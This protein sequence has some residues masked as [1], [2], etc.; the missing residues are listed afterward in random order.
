MTS[1]AEKSGVNENAPADPAGASAP[2]FEAAQSPTGQPAASQP[3]PEIVTAPAAYQPPAEQ[4]IMSEPVYA[5]PRKGPVRRFIRSLISHLVFAAIVTAAAFG[6][7]YHKEIFG[8]LGDELCTDDRLGGYMTKA[9][10]PVALEPVKAARQ[11]DGG[12]APAP[13]AAKQATSAPSTPV[14]LAPSIPAVPAAAPAPAEAQ[15]VAK[16]EPGTTS[17][18]KPESGPAKVITEPSAGAQPSAAAP[19]A[20]TP[21]VRETS[22]A[23]PV[24][25][26]DARSAQAHS[27]QVQASPSAAAANDA[28]RQ[29][30]LSPAPDTAAATTSATA[31]TT[32][33]ATAGLM[34]EWQSARQKYSANKDEAVEAYRSLIARHPMIAELRGELGN[35]YY[36]LGRMKEAAEQ[37]YEAALRHL[38]GPDPGVASCLADVI[39][40]IDPARAEALKDKTTKPC[41]YRRTQ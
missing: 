37:Y 18:P 12:T 16:A 36:G 4:P 23:T 11:G 13:V 19:V 2:H 30:A 22:A 25:A 28:T 38:Q 3:V 21:S 26:R 8:R 41:P 31:D 9:K 7:V 32:K 10:A 34:A 6:Y 14:V 17:A 24:A 15:A 35:V 33:D 5:K 40:R 1:D 29:A 20:P 39:Q 27:E